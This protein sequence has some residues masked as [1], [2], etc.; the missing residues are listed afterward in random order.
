MSLPCFRREGVVLRAL[1]A[2]GTLRHR[3]H[4]RQQVKGF[5]GPAMVL[6]YRYLALADVL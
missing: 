2:E 4:G 1:D 6:R 5:I 3:R